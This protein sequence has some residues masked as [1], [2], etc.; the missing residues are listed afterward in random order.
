[1]IFHLP[2]SARYFGTIGGVREDFLEAT[3]AQGNALGRR[4]ASVKNKPEKLRLMLQGAEASAR[5]KAIELRTPLSRRKR[6]Q[7]HSI[8][9]RK[10]EKAKP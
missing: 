10:P 4:Y 9:P 6:K 5:L 1:M 2:R 3:H 7:T 8:T